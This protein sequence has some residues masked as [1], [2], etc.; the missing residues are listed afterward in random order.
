VDGNINDATFGQVLK[1]AA[2]RISQAA[3][4]FSF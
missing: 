4:K 1:A 2:L 3:L